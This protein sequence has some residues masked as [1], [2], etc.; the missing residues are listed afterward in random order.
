MKTLSLPLALSSA[1]LLVGCVTPSPSTSPQD[2]FFAALTTRCG[3]AYAGEL[4]SD[5]PADADMKGKAMVMHIRHCTPDRIEIP[6]HIEGLGPDGGWD[7][8]RTWIISRTAEG[9]RLKHDHRHA[10]GSKDDVTMYGGDT[11]DAGS[12]TQQRF[13]V[14]A[15]SIAMF[16]AN[17]LGASVTNIWTVE[18]DAEGFSYALDR[19][20]RHFRATFDYDRPV[21]PPPAPW[22][23]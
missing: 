3:Q 18:T 10:D 12:A 19:E 1:A 23:W 4:A 21:T 15:E 9:L 11:A 16:K 5:Q 17:G 14:D 13:P 6:F 7:R 8:S 20:G 2:M 22:G